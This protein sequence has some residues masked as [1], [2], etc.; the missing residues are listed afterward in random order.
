MNQLF[1]FSRLSTLMLS[2][3]QILMTPIHH[4][5]SDS[6]FCAHEIIAVMVAVD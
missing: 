1:K 6:E 4:D 5:F 2:S 3:H